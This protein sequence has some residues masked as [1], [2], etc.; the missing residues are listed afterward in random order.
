ME[1]GGDY[2]LSLLLHEKVNHYDTVMHYIRVVLVLRLNQHMF[3]SCWAR[4]IAHART[5]SRTLGSARFQCHSRK[6]T[7]DTKTK[8]RSHVRIV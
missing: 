6:R 7:F 3:N 5:H 4:A 1:A 2:W 8:A